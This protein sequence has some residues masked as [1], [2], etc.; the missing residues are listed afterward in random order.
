[1]RCFRAAAAKLGMRARLA[2]VDAGSSAPAAQF[3]DVF[4]RVP[5]CDDAGF[6]AALADICRR[7]RPLL[8]VPTIDTELP[9]FAERIDELARLGV[10]IACSAPEAVSIAADKRLTHA[11]LRGCDFPT[12]R[13]GSLDEVCRNPESWRF[14]VIVKPV[15]GSASV[16]VERIERPAQLF[17]LRE[18]RSPE[19]IVQEL[20]P[21]EEHT[22]HTYVDRRGECLAATPCRRLEVRG[23]EVSKGLTVRHAGLMELAS[24]ISCKL[25]GAYGP[26]NVQIFL[27]D[28]GEMRVIEIN[29]RFGGGYPLAD[30][31]GMASPRWLIEEAMGLRPE[32][33]ADWQDDLAMLRYD[34]AVFL[35]GADLRASVEPT[36]AAG[37]QWDEPAYGLRPA[38]IQA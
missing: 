16:G 37:P 38:G 7:E 9:V 10:R 3:A 15:F 23:G 35:P 14:P 30:R 31:A 32:P 2:A 36:A 4:Y 1:M 13:Q 26:L 22:V 8:I 6:V 20:A 25:P 24:R 17:A 29:P 28:D 33:V 5:R 19:L 21:G 34:E 27:A 11:W 18:R 12:V